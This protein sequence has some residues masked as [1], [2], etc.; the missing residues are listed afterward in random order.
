M[1]WYKKAQIP[2]GT[3][4]GELPSKAIFKNKS[5]GEITEEPVVI[6]IENDYSKRYRARFG[7]KLS[8][9]WEIS[10]HYRNFN[11]RRLETKWYVVENENQILKEIKELIDS[12]NDANDAKEYLK[13]KSI[14][15][16]DIDF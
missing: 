8:L 2:E 13:M 15:L 6:Y 5:K 11:P 1:N 9:S 10:E 16:E 14:K 7:D 12:Y 3:I 4:I